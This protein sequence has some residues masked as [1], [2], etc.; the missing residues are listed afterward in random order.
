MAYV[1][2]SVILYTHRPLRPIR[3]IPCHT[4]APK[5]LASPSWHPTLS[6]M[7]FHSAQPTLCHRALFEART[8]QIRAYSFRSGSW[9]LSE[10]YHN[11]W[12]FGVATIIRTTTLIFH[13]KGFLWPMKIC[14][15]PDVVP[16]GLSHTKILLFAIL[17]SAP[18]CRS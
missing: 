18:Y 1:G 14:F 7:V 17:Q 13:T 12:I 4:E 3:P 15:C 6:S 5:V 16:D 2:P 8:R 9:D 11:L 10:C